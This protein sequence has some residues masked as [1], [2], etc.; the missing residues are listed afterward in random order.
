VNEPGQSGGSS[1]TGATPK[2]ILSE[3]V[4]VTFVGLGLAF[5]ANAISPRGLGLG[6]N[7]FPGDSTPRTTPVMPSASTN[8]QS[9]GSAP[10]AT[11]DATAARLKA[12]GLQ[13]VHLKETMALFKSAEFES[14][15]VVFLDARPDADFEAG[16]IPG[17]HAFNHYQAP[18][19]LPAVLPV[20][21]KAARVVVYCAGGECEDSE[22]AALTLRDVGVPAEKLFVYPGGMNEWRANRQPIETGARKSGLLLPA[23]Q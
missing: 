4:L 5:V 3:C 16:H 10:V 17:A 1:G 21:A 7:Y 2:T 18:K 20:C 12:K 9:S 22:F 6:R 14:E 8:L 15:A 11:D 13:V 23:S 19:Y